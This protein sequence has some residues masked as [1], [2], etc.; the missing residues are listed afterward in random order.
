[1]KAAGD[2]LSFEFATA[3]RIVFGPGSITKIGPLAAELGS[4]VLVVTGSDPSR[5]D[6]VLSSLRGSGLDV[7]IFS[8]ER[9]PDVEIAR[10][11]SSLAH[12]QRIDLVIGL[13]GGSVLDAAKAIA[14]LATNTQD[15]L[16]YLEVIGQGRP[17]ENPPLPCIAIPT[18]SGTGSE[19]TRNAVL[20]SPE[21]RVKVS[22]RSSRMLPRLALVDPELTLDLPP[23]I[24]ATTGLDAITQLIEPFTCNQAN[25]MTDAICREG[26]RRGTGAIRRVYYDGGNL[27]A[28]QE[29]SLA[30]LFG[31]LALANAKL[32]AVHGFAGVLGGRYIAPHG[33]ICA[34]LLPEVM[35]VN[36]AA[37][38]RRQPD[39]PILERYRQVAELL[40]GTTGAT[41][42]DGLIWVKELC[43][44]LRF[45]DLHTYGIARNDFP[46]IIA[47]AQQA[48][49]MKGNPL[50][51]SPDELA[52]IL[53]SAY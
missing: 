8:V 46:E 18:T 38:Q 25:P 41:I 23:E 45:P 28:R 9:E 51:L 35:A 10:I 34:R 40:T 3:S 14:A 32:G 4:R 1:M 52:D 5:A 6:T 39:S 11:G 15:V 53:D 24:T 43:A 16:E 37:L 50:A 36:V 12:E 19:V 44:E 42:E 7:C 22:L 2:E 20:G 26:I 21:H 31:G 47:L 17:L 29:M 27:S 48:S 33:A 30:S 49:S 13:G